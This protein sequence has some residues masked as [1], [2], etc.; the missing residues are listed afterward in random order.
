MDREKIEQAIQ[1]QLMKRAKDIVNRNAFT[2]LLSAVG[3]GPLAKIFLGRED[4]LSEEEV[5]IKQDIVLDLLCRIDDAISDARTQASKRGIDLT[6]ISGEIEAY[7]IDAE[8]V[9]GV[10]IGSSAGPTELKPG[11]HI[12][13]SGNRAKRVTGL[14]IGNNKK[15]KM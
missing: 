9:T 3:L 2:A 15:E 14:K 7:G 8:E 11:T 12:K 10:D 6:V 1:N 4:A 13:A 5:K